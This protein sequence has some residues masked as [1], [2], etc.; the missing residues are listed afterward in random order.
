MR[1][2]PPAPS[3]ENAE[4]IRACL[5]G[6]PR[7]WEAL[8]EKHKRLIGAVT[9]RYRLLPEDAADVFQAVCI[10]LYHELAQIRQPEA[11]AGWLARVTANKCFH[12]KR[13]SSQ[14]QFEPV[15]DSLPQEGTAVPDWLA[16]TER[17][18]LVRE[19]VDRLSPRC[20]ELLRMLFFEDPPRPYEEVARGLGLAKGSIGFIRGRCL[21]KLAAELRKS[22][23]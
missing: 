13:R 15:D 7:A 6:D 14:R 18:Q 21:T 16:E 20:R 4:L 3:W 17:D 1:L 8:L 5:D 10:D 2:P 22:G 9:N 23:L 19:S 11:L 12:H